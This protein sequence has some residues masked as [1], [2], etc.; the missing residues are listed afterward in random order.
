MVAVCTALDQL[1]GVESIMVLLFAHL[2]LPSEG[3]YLASVCLNAALSYA[4]PSLWAARRIRIICPLLPAQ[5]GLCAPTLAH[6]EHSLG[7]SRDPGVT[8]QR[9]LYR[10]QDVAFIRTNKLTD[11]HYLRWVRRRTVRVLCDWSFWV[12]GAHANIGDHGM[13]VQQPLHT[14]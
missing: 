7:L 10:F 9:L 13:M 3:Q 14:F 8:I 12:C 6:N 2:R 4:L 11:Q 5:L 1:L